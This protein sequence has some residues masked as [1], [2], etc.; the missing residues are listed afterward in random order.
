MSTNK[1]LSISELLDDSFYAVKGNLKPPVAGEL[2]KDY[3]II[4]HPDFKYKL[5]HKGYY[6]TTDPYSEVK[7]VHKGRV[8]FQ[9][10]IQGYGK[11]II[12]E[13]GDHYY[14]VYSK[15]GE[16]QVKQS[17]DV[18]ANEVIAKTGEYLEGVRPGIYFEIR[19][20]SDSIDPKNWM[21]ASNEETAR[22][23]HEN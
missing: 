20:F 4:Q 21:L 8:A 13:H 23:K 15:L 7:V 11:T 3:G 5:S 6:Y 19:H 2:Q 1:N 17:Q 14:T 9:G 12:I 16:I 22:R 10:E 18:D